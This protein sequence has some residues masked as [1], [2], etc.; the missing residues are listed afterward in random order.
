MNKLLKQPQNTSD[1]SVFTNNKESESPKEED[2]TKFTELMST[3]NA[4][5]KDKGSAA[6]ELQ[7]D[8][9][10]DLM[11]EFSGSPFT[12]QMRS[13]NKE[14]KSLLKKNSDASS[15]ETKINILNEASQE[16]IKLHQAD[17]TKKLAEDNLVKTF[18]YGKAGD[19]KGYYVQTFSL[20]GNNTISSSSESQDDSTEKT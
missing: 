3:D 18:N 13:L 2:I 1:N 19:K 17:V 14:K 9:S 8:I 11:T 6:Y 16:Y 7:N 15:V 10:A 20:K 4:V 5:L 12:A